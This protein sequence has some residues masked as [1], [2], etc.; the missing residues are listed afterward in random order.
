[1]AGPGPAE[2]WTAASVDLRR[3][4]YFLAVVNHGGVGRAAEAL[5]IAQPSLSQAIKTLERELGAALFVRDGRGLALT[6]AGEAL[7]PAARQLLR[8]VAAARAAAARV[9]ELAG[10]WLDLVALPTLAVDPLAALAGRFRR[11]YPRVGLNVLAPQDPDDVVA[12]VRG[13]ACELGLTLLPC[14]DP[15]LGE[16]ELTPQRF[17]VVLPPVDTHGVVE[18]R[19][20]AVADLRALA[21]VITPPGSST[22]AL[23]DQVLAVSGAEARI[24]VETDDR[25]AIV[26]LVLAG[27]GATLLPRSM[28][29]QAAQR[30][31]QVRPIDPPLIRR[32]GLVH[33]HGALS[34]AAR[35][36]L[37]LAQS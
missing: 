12:R 34:A 14:S 20:F 19:A 3:L 9:A 15:E 4:D 1:M 17:D 25:E 5:L 26:A 28:A 37:A 29:E 30:G 31:A 24:A 36:F 35:A 2:Q 16:R 27:A 10:G 32:V 7:I 11:R 6:A 18:E 13:G 33:R 22:R 21:W 8:D 23:L